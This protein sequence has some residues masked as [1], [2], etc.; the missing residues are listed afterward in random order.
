M[1]PMLLSELKFT[2]LIWSSNE[3][4]RDVS[5]A[6]S[7]KGLMLR[8]VDFVLKTCW[9]IGIHP[10]IRLLFEVLQD[11]REMLRQHRVGPD[12]FE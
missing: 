10:G 1:A 12:G 5:F 4:P 8:P 3:Q 11:I 7:R 6:C 9:L 2:S